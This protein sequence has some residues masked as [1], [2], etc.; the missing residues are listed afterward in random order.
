M[1]KCHF[2]VEEIAYEARKCRLC[3]EMVLKRYG[4]LRMIASMVSFLA[5]VTVAVLSWA[6]EHESHGHAPS[7]MNEPAHVHGLLLAVVSVFI[8][9]LTGGRR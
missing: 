4:W 6:V 8:A 1:K 2:C 5:A 3:G 7:M 9:R